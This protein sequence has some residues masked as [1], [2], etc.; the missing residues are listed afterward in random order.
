MSYALDRAVHRLTRAS[1]PLAVLF[2]PRDDVGDRLGLTDADEL[3]ALVQMDLAELAERGLHPLL[4]MRLAAA[5][6]MSMSELAVVLSGGKA[7]ASGARQHGQGG[8]R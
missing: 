8:A 1:E 3:R 5:S 4:V 2:G 6:G 7:S